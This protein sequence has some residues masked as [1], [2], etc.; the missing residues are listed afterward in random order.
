MILTFKNG[1]ISFSKSSGGAYDGTKDMGDLNNWK[2]LSNDSNDILDS[3]YGLLVDRSATLYHTYGPARG[4]INKQTDYGIGPGLVFRSQPDWSTLGWTKETGRDW[5]KEFQ[6]IV[7][8]YYRRFGFYDKQP[9]LFRSGLYGGDSFLFFLRENGLL[10]DLIETQNNQIAWDYNE[11]DYTLGIK[12]DE[13]LR[14]T[15]IKKVDGTSVDFRNSAGDQNVVQFYVKELARQLRGYPLAYSIINLARNDDTHTD[16]ITHRA[17]MESILMGTFESNGTDPVRQAQ[18]LANANRK[19]KGLTEKLFKK[20]DN[21]LNLGAGSIMTTNVGEKLTFSDL[22]TPSNNFG[23]FKEVIRDYIGMATGTPPEV[24]ASKYNTSFTAH[25]GALNDFVKSFM[26]KRILFSRTVGDVVNRE[27]LKDAVSQGFIDAPGFLSGNWRIEQ[28]YLRGMYLGPVP[29]HIN[30]LVEVRA[31]ELSVKNAFKLRSDVAALNGNEFEN[32]VSEWQEEQT[33]WAST[34][35][36]FADTVIEQE[37]M[38]NDNGVNE[39]Q[40]DE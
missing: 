33:N 18:N 1:K 22:K 5:G 12:H 38:N 7:D 3:T 8:S 13:W 36:Q 34:P 24:I 28:A 16:A 11:G 39:N 31:D 21:A 14:R 25:K 30:P 23:P 19:K 32:Y 15:G 10:T 27:I 26:N 37:E 40:E 6:K 20:Q 17:V 2:L 9:I 35:Q 4:A 29:G